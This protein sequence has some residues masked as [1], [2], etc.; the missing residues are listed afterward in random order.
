MRRG[1]KVRYKK[2][3]EFIPIENSVNELIISYGQEIGIVNYQEQR[4]EKTFGLELTDM[5][6]KH[7]K[8]ALGRAK[9]KTN[10]NLS[11]HGWAI[12][13]GENPNPIEQV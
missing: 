3:L 2:H 8:W 13:Q 4:V 9:N 12:I 6:I 5:N 1:N 10:Q 11:I 7:L